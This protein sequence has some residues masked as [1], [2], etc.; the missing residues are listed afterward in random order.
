MITVLPLGLSYLQDHKLKQNF[1]DGRNP[2]CS[3]DIEVETTVCY[4]FHCPNYLHER[5]ALLGNIKS[6]LSNILKQSDSFI[7][8]VLLFGDTSLD[9]SSNTIMLNGTINCMTSAKKYDGFTFMF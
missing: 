7:N 8:N 4:L 6:V 2:I 3:C 5:K 9:D 1:Q